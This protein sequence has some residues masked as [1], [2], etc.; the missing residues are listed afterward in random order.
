MNC[1]EWLE[2]L[3]LTRWDLYSGG[4]VPQDGKSWAVRQETSSWSP[5]THGDCTPEIPNV[6]R[7][8]LP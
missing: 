3:P 8:C 2:F 5:Q 6:G 4:K 7:E 1:L